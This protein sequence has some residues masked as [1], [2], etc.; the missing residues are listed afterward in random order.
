MTKITIIKTIEVLRA[1][2]ARNGLP[3][4]IVSDNGP[5]FTSA[6]FCERKWDH[7][8][9]ISSIPSGNKWVSR[10]IRKDFETE[11]ESYER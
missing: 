10:A 11:P 3:E 1:V 8:F 7:P 5:Q 9:P 6:E 2:F 4:Q